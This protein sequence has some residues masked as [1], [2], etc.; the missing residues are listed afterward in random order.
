PYETSGNALTVGQAGSTLIACSE[1]P[2][3]MEQ[4]SAYLSLLQSSAT[5]E[6]VQAG[7]QL[8][9]RDASGTEVLVYNAAVT[10]VV[11][12]PSDT[13]LPDDAIVTVQ[14]Q[15]VSLQDVPAEILGQ[16]E[17]QAG[18]QQAPIPYVVLYDA[19]RILP[20]HTYSMS[21]RITDGAGN[22]L[23]ISDTATLVLTRGN[24][25]H[26]VEIVAVPVN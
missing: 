10:G 16:D 8:S 7:G 11:T 3:I 13:I 23:F 24:P 6:I 25:T 21:A 9:I 22:L 18:G 19:T 2:G 20:N 14:L 17:I 5:Y 1:P 12:Y 26:D 4:E 15:D